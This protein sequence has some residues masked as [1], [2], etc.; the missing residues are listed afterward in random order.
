MSRTILVTGGGTGIGRAVAHHF[1][2]AGDDVIV[3]GRR[4]GP[5]DETAAGRPAV[6]P[7]CATTPTPGL[8]PRCSPGS[9]GGSTSW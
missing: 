1:A 5:L 4:P 7:W 2:D 6:R 9:P 8:S 3:T